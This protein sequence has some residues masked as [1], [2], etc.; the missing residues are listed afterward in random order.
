MK[1]IYLFLLFLPLLSCND[2]LDISPENSV[3]LTNYFQSE[4]DLESLHTSM[5]A[6][7]KS[8][9]KGKQPYYYMSVDADELKPNISGFRELDVAT[10]TTQTLIGGILKSTWR[11]IIP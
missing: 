4:A 6:C 7:M 2:W 8:A 5:M 9:C 10:H 11:D 1:K 3:T